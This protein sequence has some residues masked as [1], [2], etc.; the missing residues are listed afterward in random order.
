MKVIGPSNMSQKLDYYTPPVVANNSGPQGSKYNQDAV[1]DY[2]LAQFTNSEGTSKHSKIFD[3]DKMEDVGNTSSNDSKFSP[4]AK[5]EEADSTSQASDYS[6]QKLTGNINIVNQAVVVDNLFE[7]QKASSA[8]TK[9]FSKVKK[10][11][12]KKATL[13]NNEN[14]DLN[15]VFGQQQ[16]DEITKSKS[17]RSKSKTT[18]KTI[19]TVEHHSSSAN[20]QY[21][22]IFS[23]NSS[24]R[25]VLH[26]ETI[27]AMKKASKYLEK[28]TK[29]TKRLKRKKSKPGK[30]DDLI[31]K[32]QN[33]RKRARSPNFKNNMKD[34]N[35]K[36][37]SQRR[38]LDNL[39]KRRRSVETNKH[40]IKGLKVNSNALMKFRKRSPWNS[41]QTMKKSKRVKAKSP[42]NMIV[43]PVID[44]KRPSKN[45]DKS[46]VIMLRLNYI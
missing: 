24:K 34:L 25:V 39:R 32:L 38:M 31:P 6:P 46:L 42:S 43:P 27:N 21:M 13:M 23:T 2:Q 3:E 15:V 11:K 36:L 28:Q 41:K 44:C 17:G 8:K 22:K 9:P 18:A 40:S 20:S 1:Q 7:A 37:G 16:F 26:Q 45:K 12:N 4:I 14:I 30:I 29:A 35:K 19:S 10:I 5:I 33:L